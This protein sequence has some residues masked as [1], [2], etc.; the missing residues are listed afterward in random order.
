MNVIWCL[1][2][3]TKENGAT[4]YIPGSNKWT[5]RQDIPENAPEL[6]VPFEGKKGDVIVMD[7]RLWH[8]SGANWTKDQDRAMLF[9]YYT[10][11]LMRPI[12]NWNAKL[13]MELQESLSPE[14]RT[15][16]NL[17]PFG[18]VPIVGDM[19]FMADQFPNS[20]PPIFKPEVTAE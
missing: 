7:G 4:L 15:W 10:Y 13:P 6:L 11:P 20:Q 8:T 1:S 16:L 9:G 19:R 18:N 14:M 2:D 5:S 12:V 17:E 3:V